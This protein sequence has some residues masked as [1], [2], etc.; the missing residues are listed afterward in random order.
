MRT[1]KGRSKE[2]TITLNFE[3]AKRVKNLLGF[4]LLKPNK[5]HEG[6]PLLSFLFNDISAFVDVLFVICKPQADSDKITDEMFAAELSDEENSN[7]VIYLEAREAFFEEVIDF[8]LRNGH[9]QEA[10]AARIQLDSIKAS[11]AEIWEQAQTVDVETPSR[12]KIKSMDMNGQVSK[13]IHGV[14]STDSPELSE[15]IPTL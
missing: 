7:R 15:S 3:S 6:I 5:P 14:K 10:A 9:Q 11:E 13:A 1:F 12:E 8:F 4:D 2:W